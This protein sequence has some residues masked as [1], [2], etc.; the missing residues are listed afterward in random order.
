VPYTIVSVSDQGIG[1]RDDEA[2]KIFELF[3]Q[4]NKKAT[5]KG[6]AIGLAICKKI[7]EIHGGF[8]T[9]QAQLAHEPH[10]IATSQARKKSVR[11][12]P[13][14]TPN[15]PTAVLAGSH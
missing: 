2:E 12:A 7:M 13:E 11:A 4:L 6:S 8:I 15:L 5:N 10:S 3:S 1:F 14:R 9:A